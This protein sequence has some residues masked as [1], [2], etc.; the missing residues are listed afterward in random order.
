[1]PGLSS[2]HPWLTGFVRQAGHAATQVGGLA[3]AAVPWLYQAPA[4]QVISVALLGGIIVFAATAAAE[5]WLFF[6][7]GA[8]TGT[9]VAAAAVAG[10]LT[11]SLLYQ[12][13]S[14]GRKRRA[15][16]LHHLEIISETNHHIRNAMETV[17]MSAYLS[18]EKQVI[19]MIASATARIEWALR[20][21]LGGDLPR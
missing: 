2:N 17:Q 1:M 8:F 3:Q 15:M 4:W 6:E 7:I 19:D 18:G 20:D 9:I 14:Y 21:I 12:I 5:W 13:I 16:L 10:L 11:A